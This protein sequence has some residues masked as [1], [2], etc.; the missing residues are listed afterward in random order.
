M[1]PLSRRCDYDKKTID[2]GTDNCSN[3]VIDCHDVVGYQMS[4]YVEIINP[5]TMTCKLM[6]NGEIVAEYKVEQCD[7]CSKLVKFDSF[8]YQKGYDRTENI[9]WFCGDCR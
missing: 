9:I 1:A 5:R 3:P 8:G 6:E 7:K 4:D 2:C